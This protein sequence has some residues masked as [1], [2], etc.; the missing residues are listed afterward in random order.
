MR[1]LA[2]DFD[3]A[4][5][6]AIDGRL[7]GVAAE[8]GV[9]VPWAVE[10]GSRAWG[11]ASPDS[12]YD[13]RFFFV[14]PVADYRRLWPPRDVIETPLEGLLDV[15]GWD[16]GKAIRLATAGNATVGEWLRSP[17]VYD[18]DAA[19]R[20]DL[21]DVVARVGD[22]ARVRRHYLHVGRAQWT[23]AQ[24]D[25]GQVRLK[26]VFYAIRPA[27]TLRWLDDHAGVPPMNLDELLRQ[28]D[29]PAAVRDELAELRDLKS[30][31]RELGSAPV[32]VAV[33]RWVAQVFAAEPDRGT[34]PS[35]GLRTEAEA[36]FAALLDRWAP[37]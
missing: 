32:P 19:F 24:E 14:R 25:A 29:V 37:A 33:A 26:R 27:V 31:T 6:A 22:P 34:P 13:C 16:L 4:A 18:G 21:L 11:F 3:P 20:D 8:H 10:S 15:N 23:R 17:L 9:R 36:G 35:S 30:R 7:A 1:S 5:V 28:A 2:D 12:D